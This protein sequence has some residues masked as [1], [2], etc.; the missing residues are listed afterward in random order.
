MTLEDLIS[1]ISPAGK[2]ATNER[3]AAFE[4]RIGYR[5]P[6]DYKALLA[7]TGGGRVGRSVTLFDGSGDQLGVV[8]GLG[9]DNDVSVETAFLEPAYYPIPEGLLWI[10]TDGGGNGIMMSLRDDD[11]HGSIYFVDHEAAAYQG[12]PDPIEVAIGNGLLTEL[13][14]T[15]SDFVAGLVCT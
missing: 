10:M 12:D 13:S 8:G 2:G 6:D 3:I 4:N 14:P 9:Q 11:R 1:S 7:S 5:L 15:F